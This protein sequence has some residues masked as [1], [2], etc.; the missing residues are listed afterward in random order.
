[1]DLISEYF[2]AHAAWWRSQS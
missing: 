2:R 1:L